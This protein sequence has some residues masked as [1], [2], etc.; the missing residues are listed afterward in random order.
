MPTEITIPRLGWSM[1]EGVFSEWLKSA[2]EQIAV[3]EMLFVLEGDKAAHEIESFDAGVL[4]IPSDA[5]RPG[6]TVKVGQVIGFLLAGGEIAPS[7]V[8][9]ARA[10]PAPIAA[11]PQAIPPIASR[12]AG[13]AARRLAR[14][15]GID[16]NSVP[17][18]DPTGRV[19]R[20]DVS[21]FAEKMASKKTGYAPEVSRVATPRAR[22]RAKETGVD[23]R[24][25]PGTG[26][27]GR[28][29]ERDVV[30]HSTEADATRIAA[31]PTPGRFQRASKIRLT[32]A[33]RMLAG[34]RQAA[35]V[36][37]A[38]K[39]DASALVALRNQWR[40]NEDAHIVAS[41]TDMLVKLAALALQEMP[42][43]NACWHDDGI[44]T[45]D[46]IHIAIAVDTESGLMAPVI[47]DADKL[48]LLQIAVHSR[49]LV[50]QAR[51]GTLNQSQLQGGTFTIT[52]L[53]MYSI[54]AFTPVLNLPQAAILGV[55][56]IVKEPVVRD[57]AIVVGETLSLSLT[58]DHRVVD[59]APAA[60]WL[61]RLTQLIEGPGEWLSR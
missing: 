41:Y 45:Y 61:Q 2:G 1:E 25:L 5:P 7:S 31:P 50:A 58:F 30:A 14:K 18:P 57:D 47:P 33:Q 19:L 8:G 55:G 36:T 27:E 42:Q 21:R 6:D 40:T 44:W 13:P 46:A 54:D 37:L 9:G 26:R 43:L 59:G 22:R 12:A 17:T 16:L 24:N 3:G 38:T 49:E 32:L 23:W 56:R 29:R 48:S 35:P 51:A 11:A 10:E 60:R 15:L 39:V 53:G 28:V 34:V 4:C 52:N 20:E